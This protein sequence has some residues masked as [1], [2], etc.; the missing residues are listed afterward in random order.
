MKLSYKALGKHLA[1]QQLNLINKFHNFE[2][3]QVTL[4]QYSDMPFCSG[5]ADIDGVDLVKNK[6]G[7]MDCF[8][9]LRH[10]NCHVL[11]TLPGK[12]KVCKNVQ[13][14]VSQKRRRMSKRNTEKKKTSCSNFTDKNVLHIWKKRIRAQRGVIKRAK[15]TID[16]LRNRVDEMKAELSNTDI[17]SV[18]QKC[19]DHQIPNIQRTLIEQI[20]ASSKVKSVKGRRNSEDW[21]MLCILMHIRSPKQYRHLQNLGL[22]PLPCVRTVRRYLSLISTKCGFDDKFFELFKTHLDK[23]QPLQKQGVILIDEISLREAVSVSSSTLTYQGLVDCGDEGK[24]ASTIKEKAKSALVVMFQPLADTYT[25]PVGV[26]ASSGPV[27]GVELAKIVTNAVIKLEKAG[28]I[29][30]GVISDGAETNRKMWKEF[31]IS[32]KLSETTTCCAASC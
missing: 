7:Y 26:F 2:E 21:M 27:H 16:R 14:T 22:L 31:E 6:I 5:I 12:C 23:K 18:L 28:A 19:T 3:L 24:K 29:V 10:N 30:H 25:Q 17:K 20:V 1:S 15:N 8:D 4:N 9:K 32:G 11:L 13:K